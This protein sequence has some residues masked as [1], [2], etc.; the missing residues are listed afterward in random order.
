MSKG[1]CVLPSLF[2]GGKKGL[3]PIYWR[4]A[5]FTK[6]AFCWSCPWSSVT[7]QDQVWPHNPSIARL[8]VNLQSEVKEMEVSLGD[9]IC[10]NMLWICAQP[11]FHS[12]RSRRNLFRYIFLNALD[13]QRTNRREERR[14][15]NRFHFFPETLMCAWFRIPGDAL[16]SL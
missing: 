16:V 9:W 15:S 12:R 8:P 5:V 14:R 2:L 11:H 10:K 4:R 1:F 6:Q 13:K 3:V 7:G